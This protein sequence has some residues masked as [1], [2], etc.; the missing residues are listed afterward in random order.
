MKFIRI[1]GQ[2]HMPR[3]AHKLFNE[4][5]ELGLPLSVAVY[6]CLLQ[7]YAECGHFEEAEDIL[8]EMI[9]SSDAKPNTVTYTGLVDCPTHTL[10]FHHMNSLFENQESQLYVI[11][12]LQIDDCFLTG[13][14]HAYGKCGLYDDMW[15][16]FN[17]MKTV[18]IPPDEFTYRSLV[19]AY[20]RGGLFNRMHK[21]IREM[22]ANDI[23]P[24]SATMNVVVLS[25]A[26]AGLVEEMEKFYRITREYGFNGHYLTVKAMVT[27]YARKSLFFQLGQFVTSVGMKRRTMGNFLWNSLLL[28]YAANFAMNHLEEQFENMKH[29]G[30]TPDLTTY[31]IMALAYGRMQQFWDLRV[32]I[33]TMQSEGIAPD[34]VTY[35]AVVDAFLQGNVQSKLP[36]ALAELRTIDLVAEIATDPLV[37]EV[38]GKGNLH[39]ACETLVRNMQGGDKNQRTYKNLIGYY[40][41]SLDDSRYVPG[42]GR[43]WY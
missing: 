28:S 32:M 20:A 15:R 24:D 18:G 1:L 38:F 16:T 40:L 26:E 36:D 31:N 12:C 19:K 5:R 23:Y 9:S 8:K 43:H 3:E 14:I 27:T 21:T 33:L 4:M 41:Q 7:C 10:Y 42:R 11:V 17:T 37:F 35:G 13:L 34:L 30:F 25:Y 6:T 29:A 22:T 39:V 2:A